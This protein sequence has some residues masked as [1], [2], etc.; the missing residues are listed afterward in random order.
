MG[1]AQADTN[2]AQGGF[3]LLT[4]PG[5]GES[6]GWGPGILAAPS[7]VTD[8]IFL[9]QFHQWNLNTVYWNDPR[10]IT[11]VTIVLSQLYT[12]NSLLLQVDNNDDYHIDYHGADHMWHSLTALSPPDSAGLDKVAY[13]LPASIQADGFMITGVNGDYLYAVSEFQAMGTPA[14][15]EPQSY[16]MLGLGLAALGVAARRRKGQA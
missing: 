4:G 7:S 13:V 5:I 16:A 15:P 14:V 3:V 6:P 11:N 8:G 2:V 9:E 1:S 12:I 10:G